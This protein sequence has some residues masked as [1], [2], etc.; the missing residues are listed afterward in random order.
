MKRRFALP[1]LA[2]VVLA[3]AA[4]K[5][6]PAPAGSAPAA[7][8][9]PVSIEAITAQAQGF[10][11]GSAMSARTA[12]V[13]FDPQCPHCGAL[14]Q[15]ARPLRSQTRFVWIPVGVLNEK[16]RLQGAALLS[17]TDPVAAMDQHEASLREQRGGIGPRAGT[18][19]QQQAVERNTQLMTRFGF[20]SVPT[21]VARHAQSGELV[22]IEGSVPTPVLAQRLGL[23]AP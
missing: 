5:D 22:T 12:Y 20:A 8:S 4:C 18:E 17:A 23:Q 9:V 21:V 15:A 19:A 11:L 7:G 10:S 14:W 6:S 3:L 2:A 1:A 13:F 16:S